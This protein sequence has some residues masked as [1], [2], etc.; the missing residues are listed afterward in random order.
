LL[1]IFAVNDRSGKI[2]F[3]IFFVLYT[4]SFKVGLYAQDST[5]IKIVKQALNPL[6]RLNSFRVQNFHFPKLYGIPDASANISAFRYLYAYK[7]TLSRVTLPINTRP[8]PNGTVKSGI[9]DVNLISAYLLNAPYSPIQIGVGGIVGFPTAVIPE[10]GSGK[11]TLGG[12]FVFYHDYAQNFQY[13]T[14]VT[15]QNS[16]GGDSNRPAVKR[17]VIQYFVWWLIGKGSYI[18]SS[19]FWVFN[20][21]NGTYSV[22]FGLG[23]GKVL[24]VKNVVY[25]FVL[26]P[27]FTFYHYGVGEPRLIIFSALH[28]QFLPKKRK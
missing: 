9:G 11:W 19:P 6:V 18:T 21:E 17:L 4:F 12:T 13:G 7:R 23:V 25:N 2:I 15:Y 14:L 28:L 8:V 3:L 10:L 24:K 22:P 16:V 1:N 26:E 27:Q 5:Q 20:I